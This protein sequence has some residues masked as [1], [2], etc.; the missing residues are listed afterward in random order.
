MKLLKVPSVLIST[1]ATLQKKE[2]KSKD[3]FSKIAYIF[4]QLPPLYSKEESELLQALIQKTPKIINYWEKVDLFEV[5]EPKK[6]AVSRLKRHPLN[7]DIYGVDE[8]VKDLANQI[9]MS[10]WIKPLMINLKGQILG[11]NRRREAVNLLISQGHLPEDQ[12][13]EVSIKKLSEDEE[14]QFLILDNASRHKTNLQMLR[15][16]QYLK[17]FH[18]SVTCKNRKTLTSSERSFLDYWEERKQT[19]KSQKKKKSVK[20]RDVLGS[21][22]DVSGDQ[23][24]KGLKVLWLIDLLTD[25]GRNQEIMEIVEALNKENITVAYKKYQEWEE[26]NPFQYRYI[27]VDFGGI[28]PDDKVEFNYSMVDNDPAFCFVSKGGKSIR[29][30]RK[31]LVPVRSVN[32]KSPVKKNCQLSGSSTKP[33]KSRDPKFAVND[34]VIHQDKK[35]V[36]EEVDLS[37]SAPRYRVVFEDQSLAPSLGENLLK[38]LPLFAVGDRVIYNKDESKGVVDDINPWR[39]FYSYG[40]VF[41]EGSYGPKINESELTKD[42]SWNSADFGEIDRQQEEGG[43]GV[44]FP[45]ETQEPPDPDDF[46]DITGYDAAFRE[47]QQSKKKKPES[48]NV[49]NQPLAMKDFVVGQFYSDGKSVARLLSKSKVD[50]TLQWLGMGDSPSPMGSDFFPK[51]GIDVHVESETGKQLKRYKFDLFDPP[52]FVERKLQQNDVVVP[53]W[54]KDTG[55][56]QGRVLGYSDG[57]VIYQED[58]G[59]EHK[60]AEDKLLLVRRVI[61]SDSYSLGDRVTRLIPG[62]LWQP[63]VE[64]RILALYS[65]CCDVEYAGFDFPARLMYAWIADI[66][67][68]KKKQGKMFKSGDHVLYD[69]KRATFNKYLDDDRCYIDLDESIAGRQRASNKSIAVPLT[70]VELIGLSILESCQNIEEVRSHLNSN[71]FASLKDSEVKAIIEGLW[72][73]LSE[74]K[75]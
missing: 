74:E 37:G 32:S 55:K 34:R 5:E 22:M 19:V 33:K 61:A 43:Q 46:D 53:K 65:N 62:L 73:K 63:Q 50:L 66:E 30:P 41:D 31:D 12:E 13:V 57:L 21:F 15:E 11:G 3:D 24:R 58:S 8:E 56:G 10:G 51:E 2:T 38:K 48:G 45:D 20:V 47:W 64:G 69:G 60:L 9:K 67:S 29:V 27:G 18:Q 23:A 7:S 68:T 4:S 75:S 26:E 1:L 49:R 28:S 42:T 36:V 44:I 39:G 17:M 6:V 16:A 35:G 72:V 52:R 71:W 59:E 25:L 54:N 40:V 14:V 70:D